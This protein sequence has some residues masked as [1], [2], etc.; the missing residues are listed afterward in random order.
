MSRPSSCPTKTSS[1]SSAS[2]ARIDFFRP[3][4]R[5][6]STQLS[7]RVPSWA[8]ATNEFTRPL[9][10]TGARTATLGNFSSTFLNW[11]VYPIKRADVARQS[12]WT[13]SAR[14]PWTSAYG[15][16]ITASPVPNCSASPDDAGSFDRIADSRLCYT[17][18]TKSGLHCRKLPFKRKRRI[19]RSG[20]DGQQGMP[21]AGVALRH[22]FCRF[23]CNK[24][25]S[26]ERARQSVR[27][28]I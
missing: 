24:S 7:S 8:V 18:V 13:L 28:L 21:S 12:P 2:V 17:F 16:Q 20:H 9:V 6:H 22:P 25:K 26:H 10:G 3:G 15:V 5:S 19:S 27:S 11:G 4:S 23:H 14:H 1:T